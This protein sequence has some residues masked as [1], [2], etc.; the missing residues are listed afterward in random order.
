MKRLATA[1]LLFALG[2]GNKLAVVVTVEPQAGILGANEEIRELVLVLR[3]NGGNSAATVFDNNGE[4]IT[5]P[6]TLSTR[7]DASRANSDLTVGIAAV[8]AQ[9]RTVAGGVKT[10]AIEEEGETA[11]K[12]TLDSNDPCVAG[13]GADEGCCSD[14]FDTDGNLLA[15][16]AER[17]FA[18][19]FPELC[20]GNEC[21][22]GVFNPL[23]GELCDDGNNLGGDGCSEFCVDENTQAHVYLHYE[24]LSAADNGAIFSDLVY[25]PNLAPGGF[26]VQRNEN[27]NDGTICRKLNRQFV[28]LD[29]DDAGL[30]FNL[31]NLGNFQ[32]IDAA[33]TVTNQGTFDTLFSSFTVGLFNDG[34]PLRLQ[35]AGG[36][37]LVAPKVLFDGPAPTHFNGADLLR[38][39]GDNAP[40]VANLLDIV[41]GEDH[42]IEW[43]P[44]GLNETMLM[45]LYTDGFDTITTC[46]APDANGQMTIPKA[47]TQTLPIGVFSNENNDFVSGFFMSLGYGVDLNPAN[48]AAFAANELDQLGAE[49][50]LLFFTAI[51]GENIF[52][53]IR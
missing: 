33:G 6:V 16:C 41:R 35:L 46:S 9:G 32:A 22:D 3:D 48:G 14:F 17:A 24:E 21:G 31:V 36:A 52:G 29:R 18:D 27:A 4:E 28:R 30:F 39:G 25:D 50:G 26:L 51:D 49:S 23:A 19:R 45:I 20:A 2:C 43:T 15:D 8:N 44:R 12:V 11:A 34:E 42:V 37:T 13:D 40:N 47:L 38:F 1:A 10:V 53:N 7:V 5:F